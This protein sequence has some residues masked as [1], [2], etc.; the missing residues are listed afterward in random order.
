MARGRMINSKICMNK[1]INE[2]SDDTSRLA[3][4]WLVSFADVDGR[5]YGDPA[6]VKS[7][8][9][10][11][12]CD[13]TVERMTTY[14]QEWHKAGLITWYESDGDHWIAFS[15][16]AENQRGLDRRKEPESDIPCPPESVSSTELVRTEYVSD[17]GEVRTEYVPGTYQVPHK[18][19]EG[20]RREE[21]RNSA[22][23][24]RP[25]A[26][27]GKNAIR[28]ALEEHFIS[29]TKI[30]PPLIKTVAQRK[31]A[32]T[33]WW[34]PLRRIAQLCDWNEDKARRLI[35]AALL[36]LRNITV[37]S[38]KSIVGTAEGI[39]GEWASGKARESPGVAVGPSSRARSAKQ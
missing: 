36:S 11:R 23:A 3:F 13:V 31:A 1:K 8:L 22:S 12:R 21:N 10:P 7:R 6:L 34:Q 26:S 2:L 29:K 24:K 17:M 15:K 9:F 4:T 38:P 18:R 16:F 20:N 14:I 28:K 33:K 5:T 35:D 37:V 30:P 39:I 19:T 25:R 32:G 27:P